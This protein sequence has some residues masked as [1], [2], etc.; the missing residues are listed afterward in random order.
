[1]H[2]LQGERNTENGSKITIA[3]RT[4][5]TTSSHVDRVLRRRGGEVSPENAKHNAKLGIA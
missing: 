2:S 4:S 1:M 3:G 5:R